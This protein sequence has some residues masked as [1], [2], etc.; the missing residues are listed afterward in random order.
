M[1]TRASIQLQDS[2]IREIQAETGCKFTPVPIC[3][4]FALILIIESGLREVFEILSW[5]V[6]TPA[7]SHLVSISVT[8]I[9]EL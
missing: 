7:V 4:C 5:E 6:M 3:L 2:E 8:V 9:E 1:G